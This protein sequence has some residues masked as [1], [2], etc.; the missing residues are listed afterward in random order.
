MS[1]YQFNTVGEIKEYQFLTDTSGVILNTEGTLFKFQKSSVQKIKTPDE[2]KITDFHF[3]DAS[4][5]AIV[6]EKKSI[7]PQQIEGSLNSVLPLFVLLFLLP[8]FMKKCLKNSRHKYAIKK[9]NFS[10]FYLVS[11]GA[12]MIGCHSYKQFQISDPNSEHITHIT[13]DGIKRFGYHTLDGKDLSF[14]YFAKTEN[15]GETWYYDSIPTNFNITA[16]TASKTD[17]FIGTF[18]HEKHQDGDILI[19][20]ILLSEKEKGPNGID[21]K[22]FSFSKGVCGLHY[23]AQDSIIYG[24]GTDKRVKII[25]KNEYSSTIA[26]IVI[27]S[28]SLKPNFSFID[29][30]IESIKLK[31][32]D[33]VLFLPRDL[34]VTSLA[35]TGNGDFWITASQ[36]FGSYYRRKEMSMCVRKSLFHFTNGKWQEMRI[37]ECEMVRDVVFIPETEIGYVIN[38]ETNE[39]FKTNDG[40][41]TWHQTGISKVLKIHAF[42]GQLSLLK[43]SSI[44]EVI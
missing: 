20:P 28:A 30:P 18:A 2:F 8:F 4:H 12:M 42:N 37:S 39:L 10:L 21:F 9:I 40:G 19:N 22:D 14:K 23:F 33:S 7:H 6:G 17:Y 11:A 3:A 35:P 5:A 29:Y 26:N 16:I 34:R 32:R 15:A 41:L 38:D 24:F 43:E 36:N 44:L 31:S 27:I 1:N 13:S 25:P